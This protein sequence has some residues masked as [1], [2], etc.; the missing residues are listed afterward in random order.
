[1]RRGSPWK[2]GWRVACF[3]GAQ[4]FLPN[5]ECGWRAFQRVVD[6]FCCRGRQQTHIAGHAVH[7]ATNVLA[8]KLAEAAEDDGHLV[9]F[10]YLELIVGDVGTLARSTNGRPGREVDDKAMESG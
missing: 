10:G 7:G 9:P 5:P 4:T 6:C 2:R 1:M 3:R 8:K